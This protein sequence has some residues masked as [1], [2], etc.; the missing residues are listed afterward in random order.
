MR[1]KWTRL[2]VDDQEKALLFYRDILG[3][4]ISDY[5]LTPYKLYFSFSSFLYNESSL[6]KWQALAIALLVW[7]THIVRSGV[8]RVLGGSLRR[9]L[10]SSVSN[11]KS[12]G[13]P[14]GAIGI[15]AIVRRP[16]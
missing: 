14:T 3:F 4:G 10:A 16:R 13:L 6:L 9:V 5:G 7:G 15:G 12:R 8:L 11:A 2:Y 1:I